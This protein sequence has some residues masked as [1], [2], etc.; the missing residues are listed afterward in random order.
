MSFSDPKTIAELEKKIQRL[1]EELTSSYKRNSD[2]ATTLI[3]LNQRSKEIQEENKTKE[4]EYEHTSVCRD[5]ELKIC[6]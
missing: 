2:N 1:Q 5:D 3:E 4:L 6:S